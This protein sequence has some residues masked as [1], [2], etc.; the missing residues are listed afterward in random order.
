MS[1]AGLG[2]AVHVSGDLVSKIEK[3]ALWPSVD[4]IQRCDETLDTCGILARLYR[5]A[6]QEH[7]KPTRPRLSAHPLHRLWS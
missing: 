1:L 4:L 5:L 6:E 3:A 2:R 7:R